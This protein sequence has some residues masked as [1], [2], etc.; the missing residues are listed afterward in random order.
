MIAMAFMAYPWAVSGLVDLW[1]IDLGLN[2]VTDASDF[3]KK[4]Y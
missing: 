4:H 3:C 1:H 2:T